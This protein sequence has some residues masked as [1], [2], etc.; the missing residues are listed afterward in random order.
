LLLAF[1]TV[2]LLVA[3]RSDEQKERGSGR[4]FSGHRKRVELQE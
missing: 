4:D 1:E 3:G 2:V